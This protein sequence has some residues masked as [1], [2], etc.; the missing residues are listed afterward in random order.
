MV[1]K[2]PEDLD[3]VPVDRLF[4]RLVLCEAR[5]DSLTEIPGSLADFRC[6]TGAEQIEWLPVVRPRVCRL[7]SKKEPRRPLGWHW[8]DLEAFRLWLSKGGAGEL[9]DDRGGDLPD[10]RLD[11]LLDD[12]LDDSLGFC[13]SAN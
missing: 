10:V 13:R 1:S 7:W 8:G 5:E 4:E 11:D 2:R 3:L 6:C 12:L 9:L